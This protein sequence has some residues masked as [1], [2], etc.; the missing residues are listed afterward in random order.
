[1]GEGVGASAMILIVVCLVVEFKS[2]YY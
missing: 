1:M 2:N